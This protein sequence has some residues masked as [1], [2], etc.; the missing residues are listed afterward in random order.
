MAASTPSRAAPEGPAA[1]G[2]ARLILTPGERDLGGPPA[3]SDLRGGRTRAL[4]SAGD[5]SCL[6]K[7][8][9]DLF[10]FT[11]LSDNFS[12]RASSPAGLHG[13][14]SPADGPPPADDR[15]ALPMVE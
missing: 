6:A 11:Q 5:C 12:E 14:P 10:K 4:I 1:P 9:T 2:P 15:R 13:T 7:P 8:L 3:D